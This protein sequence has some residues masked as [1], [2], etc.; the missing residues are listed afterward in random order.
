[1]V[2][3]SNEAILA[4]ILADPVNNQLS[5]KVS[6]DANTRHVQVLQNDIICALFFIVYI[7]TS[8]NTRLIIAVKKS[9]VKFFKNQKSY[10][11]CDNAYTQTAI[12]P[13]NTANTHLTENFLCNRDS[14]I[15]LLI[16][17]LI[18]V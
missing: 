14:N 5:K 9:A 15:L 4:P 16:E 12:R 7:F 3:T 6:A 11:N 17:G 1:M 2:S 10:I 13:N 8:I 18:R